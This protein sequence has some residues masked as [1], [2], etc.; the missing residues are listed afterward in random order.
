MKPIKP[1]EKL[2]LLL[3][4]LLF[5][6]AV[7]GQNYM[8]ESFDD[9]TFPPTGWTQTQVSGTGLWNRSTSGFN[10]T[11]SPHSGAGMARFNSYSYDAGTSAAIVSSSIDLTDLT[12]LRLQFW[13]Y[14]DNGSLSDLDAV[15][16]YI[17]TTSS[18]SGAYLL[19]TRYRPITAAPAE[20]SS[21]WYSYEFD[22]PS[23][24]NSSSNYIIIKG[25]KPGTN[26]R[27]IFID[28]V[29]IYKPVA[30]NNAPINFSVSDVS[31]TGMTV[32]W[33]DNSTNEVGF[34]V[35]K[36]TDGVNYTK[37]GSDIPT[38]TQ[39]GT[40]TQYSQA[41]TGL[42]P[43]TTYYF[44][45]SAY[46]DAES[47]YLTG[48]QETLP[49]GV[50]TSAST[51][52]WSDP[53]TWD[54]AIVPNNT[55]NVVITNGH[56]VTVN[57]TGSFNNLTVNGSLAF[58]AF[59]LTG[60]DVT[61]TETGSISVASGSTA[62]ISTSGNISN[63]GTFDFFASD[64]VLGRITFTGTSAQTF[65]A[66]GTTDMGNVTV[67]KGSSYSQIAEIVANG[68]FTIKG[69]AAT[70][71]LT[72]T[73]GTLKISGTAS[74]SSSVFPSGGYTISATTGFW[75]NNPNFTV[76][77]TTS[78]ATINGYF[79]LSNGTFSVGNSSLY[80]L[81]AGA[82]SVIIVEGGTLN[83]A[84]RF[85]TA[86]AIN[87]SQSGGV[88]NVNLLGNT[89]TNASFG[90]VSTSNTINISGGDINL[91]NRNTNAS[92]LDY[93]LYGSTVNITG[94]TLNIGTAATATN[95]DFRIQGTLPSLVIDNT[96]NAKTALLN[97]ATIVRG[98]L[99]VNTGATLN[100]QANSIQ[101]IGNTNQTG[102]IVNNGLITN[103]SATGVNRFLF[104]GANGA[105]TVS[106][107][108]TFGDA[109][110]PFAGIDFSNASGVSFE[111]VVVT[112]R[113]NLITGIVS[114]A[115]NITLGNGVASTPVVQRGGTS[116]VI[117]GSLDQTPTISAGSSYSVLYSTALQPFV[118]GFELPTSILGT[119]ELAT[120]VDVTLGIASSIQKLRFAASNSGKL[121]TSNDNLLTITGTP[122][123]LTIG[124]GNTGYIQGPMAY[125]LPSSLLSGS[126]YIYP[127]GKGGANYFELVNPTTNAGGSVLVKA[128]VFDAATGGTTGIDIQEGSLGSR[129]WNAEITSGEENFI[130][131]SVRI[132][133]VTPAFTTY[134]VLAQSATLAGEYNL[135]SSN[136]PVLNTITSNTISSLGYF[137]VG[138]Q[139]PP[140]GGAVTGGTTICMG[141][142]SGELTLINF[143]GNIVRWESSVT[144]FSVW[145]PILHTSNTYTSEPLN[146][147]TR[148]RAVVKTG[149]YDEV[150]SDY[151]EVLVNP[152]SVGGIV[153]GGTTI[154]SGNNS[155]ELTLNG[156]VGDIINWES[157][158][159]P[160]TE[161][162][163]IENTLNTYSSEI[164]TETTQYRAI[165]KSGV[166]DAI[167]SDYTVVNVTPIPVPTIS[168]TDALA[169]CENETF[170]VIFS[171][172]IAGDSYQ[173]LRNG[174]Q[175][176]DAN[177]NEYA[178]TIAG[179]YSVEVTV[180][181]CTGL[182][183]EIEI[184]S[185]PLPE[186]TILTTD[187]LNYCD[188]DAISTAFT[189]NIVGDRYQWLLNGGEIL[190]ATNDTY[191]ATEIGIFSVEV[192]VDGC[193]GI[194]NEFEIVSNPIPEP[195]ISTTNSLNYCEG[196]NISIEF[197]IDITGD[198][199]Q[200]LLNG[201][202]IDGAINSTYT[203]TAA[204]AHSVQVT[205]NSCTGTSNEI[206]IVVNPTPSPVISALSEISYCEG[207]SIS[208][209]LSID[210]T[211]DSYQWLLNGEAIDGEIN[212][213]YTATV[214]GVYSVVVTIGE[215]TG[216]S[217][218]IAIVVNA[219]PS[220][221]LTTISETTYCEGESISVDFS[222]DISGNSYQ[223]LLNGEAIDGA[224]NSTY[225]AAAAGAYSVQVTTNSCTGTSNEIE[226]IVSP[227]PVA[228]I[229]TADNLE[230]I[231]GEDISVT[232]TV[233]IV[234][235]FYQWLLNGNPID[236]ANNATFTAAEVG[237]YSAEVTVGDCIG[238]SNELIITAN[239]PQAYTVSFN[240]SNSQSVAIEGAE[241]IVTGY[242]PITT[243]EMGIA[244][245]DLTDNSY[246]FS[247]TASLYQN[248]EGNFNVLGENISVPV[249]MIP[250]NI[251]GNSLTS[252]SAYP[253]PLSNQIQISNAELVTRVEISNIIGQNIIAVKIVGENLINTS[254]LPAGIYL[255]RFIGNNGESITR[256]MIKK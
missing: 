177:S 54:P 247:V 204:G 84:S 60:K 250:T 161:W 130:S 67:N 224:I 188:G 15:D 139:K 155:G 30:A 241:V 13:F 48:S 21:G 141:S 146:E 77:G 168:T 20:T 243:N 207:E 94:G 175:I 225:T 219:I 160:F 180:D 26:G 100:C 170:S 214:A 10:P 213:D 118:T 178:A 53:A 25:T 37:N 119:L 86:N 201:E 256:K 64:A 151:T 72:L 4:F 254:A 5:N 27:N 226:V 32:R 70:N 251:Y 83:L 82:G 125:V 167:E 152:T 47:A 221:V 45:I 91:V 140:V 1:F 220:P 63:N 253:N 98:N 107:S 200:W 165:I 223:W 101:L 142:N 193:V 99:T 232:F 88:I 39:A 184:V 248:Y 206:E 137:T 227:V 80:M 109:T 92:P 182:S 228:T 42:L 24:Y 62:N 96:T 126:T 7:V 43:G 153:E 249:V 252:V 8:L 49:A 2:M 230:W 117:V 240:V 217:N 120:N 235:D 159:S 57:S 73:N 3:A 33:D 74:A 245:I 12:G 131:S 218:F 38:T 121:I 52:N 156:Y 222:I 194:S 163:I 202:A 40:G 209:D 158:V 190:D 124:A 216:N 75:L 197:T 192:T 166:C 145:E 203:A 23:S 136:I 55:N 93:S 6:I 239:P 133:Q 35:Y 114:G 36:S 112:N 234:G 16:I 154:C 212:P 169:Y 123:D 246:T 237:T 79:R 198:S 148:F 181:G 191:T 255:V 150:T 116:S 171:I 103:T 199:Y 189:I 176:D 215:C 208:V 66:V 50:I 186:A 172:D 211:G 210:I 144:P 81:G 127:I 195:I 17:N 29:R 138:T 31:Q 87:Y 128:E 231:I 34:R 173:W 56:T 58:Q 233:D 143:F 106:G 183:N 149:A 51:G 164:L 95:F 71:F 68:T 11:C 238:T 69:G 90:L 179:Q 174:V 242:A 110:T 9:A 65:D 113:V 157:S 89:S 122:A 59:T 44:R 104:V 78:S 41:I 229:S 205:T 187:A 135:A 61:I 244:L 115:N 147:N 185:K 76:L 162:T 19:G 18:L 85:Y 132:T 102:N 111:T 108:G 129:Y 14:R 105:Q 46:V 28:D 22:I 97:A 196:D 134:N 236:A